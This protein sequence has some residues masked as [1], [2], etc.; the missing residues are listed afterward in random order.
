MTKQANL[1]TPAWQPSSRTNTGPVSG[2]P[3]LGEPGYNLI[4]LGS[5]NIMSQ[6]QS[7]R[8]ELQSKCRTES[9]IVW[10]WLYRTGS[11][12]ETSLAQQSTLIISDLNTSESP[13]C[14]PRCMPKWFCSPQLIVADNPQRHTKT[15]KVYK[16]I[17][18][19]ATGNPVWVFVSDPLSTFFVLAS[20][21]ISNRASWKGRGLAHGRVGH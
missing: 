11:W 10:P 13:F 16:S 8:S 15:T 21:S 6:S 14:R 4:Q 5:Q 20:R 17:C 2:L 7:T 9:T 3:F 18:T 12:H 1:E 19:S